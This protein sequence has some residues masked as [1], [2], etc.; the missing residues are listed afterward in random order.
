MP[1]AITDT[2]QSNSA[3]QIQ[4][5]NCFQLEF[6]TI[7]KL[8]S[9]SGGKTVIQI[10]LSKFLYAK[11]RDYRAPAQE[12]EGSSSTDLGRSSW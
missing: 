6:H 1:P 9:K 8:S 4:R 12:S 11:K 10:L 3:F 2:R 7:S 5:G